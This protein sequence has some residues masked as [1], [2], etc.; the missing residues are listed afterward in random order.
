MKKSLL[1]NALLLIITFL[2]AYY[3]HKAFSMI[4]PFSAEE[5]ILKIIVY[6]LLW[7]VP[8]LLF[9]VYLFGSKNALEVI[10][11]KKGFLT[12]LTFSLITVLPMLLSSAIFGKIDTSL[13]PLALLQKTLLAGVME[14]YLFRGF[15]FGLLFSK[16]GWGFIPA[17][18]LGA[19][20]FGMG[21][22]YQGNNLSESVGVFMITGMGA[23]WFAWLYVEWDNNLWVPIFLHMLMNLSWALFDISDN[24]IGAPIANLFR[25]ITI[26]LTVVITIRNS[27][28]QGFKVN[29]SNLL[30]NFNEIKGGQN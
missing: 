13:E 2:I 7:L 10:G 11:L 5:P 21:H 12:G 26:A 4:V 22:I 9:V 24:A 3:G 25:I 16:F 30:T 18:I 6:Y 28:K 15:L 8:S 20:I 23:L 1:I 14:E 19:F 27:K 29:R 17:S